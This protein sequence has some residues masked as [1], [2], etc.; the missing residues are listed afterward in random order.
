MADC[1][2]ASTVHFKIT[3]IYIWTDSSIYD[4]SAVSV[5]SASIREL[6]TP[7]LG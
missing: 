1:V 6:A 5:L 2:L 4:Q 3:E 7:I